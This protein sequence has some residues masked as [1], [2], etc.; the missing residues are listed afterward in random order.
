MTFVVFDYDVTNVTVCHTGDLPLRRNLRFVLFLV[1]IVVV[2]VL[3]LFFGQFNRFRLRILFGRLFLSMRGK[4]LCIFLALN[5]ADYVD[6]KYIIDDK[7]EVLAY[8]KTPLLYR[9]K[10]D[11]RLK[12]A[13]ELIATVMDT[14]HFMPL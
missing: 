7:S 9:I 13:K 14:R 8:E 1:V 11:R 5:P 10:N 3:V 2:I 12:Y 4:K 6:T